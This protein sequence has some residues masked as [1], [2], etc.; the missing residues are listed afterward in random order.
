MRALQTLKEFARD[1]VAAQIFLLK[2]I[3]PF[4]SH[5]VAEEIEKERDYIL[6]HAGHLDRMLAQLKERC[7]QH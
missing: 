3:L 1:C 4:Y 6:L 2:D 7:A 5:E